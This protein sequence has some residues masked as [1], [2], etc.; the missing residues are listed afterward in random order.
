MKFLDYIDQEISKD[1]CIG[2]IEFKDASRTE[3]L[4]VIGTCGECKHWS[5]ESQKMLNGNMRNT[6]DKPFSFHRF[7]PCGAGDG[8]IHFEQK[9]VADGN[10]KCWF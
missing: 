4:H 10:I 9:E 6:C 5:A 8:C 7:Q 2:M 3:N 1:G